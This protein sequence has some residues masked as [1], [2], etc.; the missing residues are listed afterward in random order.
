MSTFYQNG[1][2]E[3]LGDELCTTSPLML[4]TSAAVWYVNS[5]TGTDAASPAGQNREK[6]LAT[7]SQA[8]TNASAGDIIVLMDGHAETGYGSTLLVSKAGLKIVGGGSSGGLPTVTLTFAAAGTITLNAAGVEIRNVKF[9]TRSAAGSN[10]KV[11]LTANT[12]CRGCYFE[13]SGND[14][15][16]AISVFTGA[17]YSQISDCTFIST[18]TSTSSQPES[19]IKAGGASTEVWISDCSISDGT[20]GFSNPFA[21]D[22]STAAMPRLKIERVSFLLGA[23][24]K[25]HASSTGYAVGCTTNGGGRLVW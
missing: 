2:G 11:T 19:A 22:L 25:V 5:A 8:V 23:D 12:A 24:G 16:P 10:P 6:P 17:D 21:L 1:C 15:G 13:C 18:A 9:A 4:P 14:T 20:V 3:S 7:L